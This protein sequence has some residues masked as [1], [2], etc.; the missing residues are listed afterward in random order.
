MEVRCATS[1]PNIQVQVRDHQSPR[2]TIERSSN[3]HTLAIC[4]P[5]MFSATLILSPGKQLEPVIHL[6]NVLWGIRQTRPFRWNAVCT[7][8]HGQRQTG[9]EP[10]QC[11]GCRSEGRTARTPRASSKPH[12]WVAASS[13]HLSLS[14]PQTWGR[15]SEHRP[16]CSSR[17]KQWLGAVTR[18]RSQSEKG[19]AG[20]TAGLF[21]FRL[22]TRFPGLKF[23]ALRTRE[24]NVSQRKEKSFAKSF[25][26]GLLFLNHFQAARV[27]CCCC[28][29]VL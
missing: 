1:R 2:T 19:V 27:C 18:P 24:E 26:K 23:Q 5:R 10:A 3:K 14:A 29:F 17:R 6:I 7:A 8:E 11:G 20:I 12:V 9:R 22:R 4:S 13:H 15:Q 21:D 16:L 28:L 25:I